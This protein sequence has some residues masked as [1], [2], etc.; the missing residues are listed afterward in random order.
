MNQIEDKV[1]DF[2]CHME[3]GE[4][5]IAKNASI[6][7]YLFELKRCDRAGGAECRAMAGNCGKEYR[8]M[9]LDAAQRYL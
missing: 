1:R 5:V 7:P 2:P 4:R 8:R 9:M 3:P 6:C